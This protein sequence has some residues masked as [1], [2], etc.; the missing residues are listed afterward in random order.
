[1][2]ALHWLGVLAGHLQPSGDISSLSIVETSNKDD[3]NK[4]TILDNRTGK[5]Y[6]IPIQNHTINAT[7]LKNIT[8]DGE[9]LM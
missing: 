5:T 9:G 8:Y 7:L 3:K 4:L 1:M 2:A 6:E